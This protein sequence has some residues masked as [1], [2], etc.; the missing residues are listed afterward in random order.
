MYC[1][2]CMKQIADDCTFCAF[3]GHSTAVQNHPHHLTPGTTLNNKYLV[4]NSIGEG[5]FGITYVGLDL[6]L[7]RKIAIKEFYPSGFA[8]RNNT[9]S[10]VVT[11]NYE[12][13]GEYF[14]KGVEHFLQEAKS[15]AKF[16]DEKSV[17]DIISFFEENNTAYIIM[18]Y[19][20]GETLS[21]RIRSKGTYEP[22]DAFKLFLPMM[23]TLEKMHREKI[24]HRDIS[25]DNIFV[26]Q[27]GSLKLIDFGSARYFAGFNKKT[28][29][30]QFKPGYAPIEQ[31]NQNGQQGPWT[32]VY[33][34]CA[35]IY[36]CITGVTPVDSLERIQND[37]LKRPSSLGVKITA[38]LENALM[39]GLEVYPENRCRS[40]LELK[41]SVENQL[42]YSGVTPAA[43]ASAV[44]P[45]VAATSPVATNPAPSA[46]TSTTPPSATN[47]TPS[48]ANNNHTVYA[49]KSY[50]NS[51]GSS[52][53]NS[54]GNSYSNSQGSSYSNS[55]GNSQGN[56]YGSSQGSSYGNTGMYNQP[57]QTNYSNTNPDFTNGQN[58]Y[59]KPKKKAPVGV[60][61][62]S[63]LGGLA[64]IVIAVIIILN[65]I[66][67]GNN[68]NPTP[69]S[70]SSSKSSI[71]S[72]SDSSSSSGSSSDYSSSESSNSIFKSKPVTKI[73]YKEYT[74][75]KLSIC[76]PEDYT[77]KRSSP[78]FYYYTPDND[79]VY[80]HIDN[81]G[82]SN[83][84][85]VF[86]ESYIS[87]L[88]SKSKNF[89][90]YKKETTS[91]AGESGY[92]LEYSVNINTT[93]CYL[94]SY[95]V[96]H[97]NQMYTVTFATRGLIQSSE[98]D[99]IENDV[100][101]MLYFEK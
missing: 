85:P 17:V 12:N 36:K 57:N 72:S 26:L 90:L 51:Q 65:M 40:M 35:T 30:V 95:M 70:S 18:E 13:E 45:V 44:P 28:L 25:P 74:C 56:S 43:A 92:H 16:H 78:N 37:S 54:Q 82:A 77:E 64:V 96:Q 61:I 6:V 7:D 38:P 34:L 76:V 50:G 22:V 62:G 83:L 9:L 79:F 55:Y 68:P 39:H 20:E 80:V 53:S 81:L 33:G 94:N 71:N 75:D 5:G 73:G 24:I 66:P 11:L 84:T 4:G 60:I 87:G 101:D 99:K 63:S 14:R 3:C 47:T 23:S 2:N 97:G 100:L 29:S 1:Y 42:S 52:Y 46:A 10:N 67:K 31:Y 27:D 88:K 15:I 86:L 98:L 48:M 59:T 32:D 69:T 91:F 89:K 49:D 21:D 8:N 19:L 58:Y 93:D 41:N